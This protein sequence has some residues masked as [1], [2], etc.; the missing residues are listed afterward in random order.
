[1]YKLLATIVKDTRILWRD[2]TG[3]SLMF[4]MPVILVIIVTNIQNSTFQL[5]SKNKLPIMIC[6]RDTGQASKQL[7][8]AIDSIGMFKVSS[9]NDDL[10]ERQIA[11]VMHDKEAMLGIII[12]A[13]FS[14]SVMAKSKNTAGKALTI[15]GLQGDTLAHVSDVDPLT[16]YYNPVMQES[17]LLSV[18]GA[19][20][21]ALQLVESGATLRS[22]Y[23]SINEKP[24]P[25]KL[26]DEMLNN[27]TV[28]NEI[29]VTKDGTA[30]IPNATQHNVPA[31]T[32]FAM[33]F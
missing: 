32:I 22:L 21:S 6:N 12:P 2:R 7:I 8:T 25:E 26:E 24:M 20:R 11:D 14:L 5:V 30:I 27:K 23:F 9:I 31:W 1:M 16:L 33:F 18:Q 29:P 17:L 19:V 28:I 13:N 15:F 4:I 10:T 3:F